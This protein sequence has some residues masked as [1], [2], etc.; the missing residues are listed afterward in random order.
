MEIFLNYIITTFNEN[1]IWQT[2]WFIALFVNI[3]AFVT[4]K[5][6]KFLIYMVISSFIWWLHFYYIDLKV[7]AYISFFDILKNLLALKYKKNEYI[8][9]FL[10]ISYFLIWFFTFEPNSLISII[11]AFNSL[12]SVFFIYYLK[13][14]KL[15]IWFLFILALWFIYNFF[16]NSLWGMLSDT[17]LFVSWIIWIFN[18]LR[19]NKN[20]SSE[21]KLDL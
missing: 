18:I 14:I 5:D 19:E 3:I 12:L 2:I 20:E 13:W 8:F 6:N 10:L 16:W 1:P 17:I 21:K 4:S 11:P 9:Y 15:K 7:A